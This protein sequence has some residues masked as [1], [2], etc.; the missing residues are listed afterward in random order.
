MTLTA[1]VFPKLRTLK[2]W[3]DKCL[4]SPFS[5]DPST[6]DM[7]IG[8]K[9]CWNLNDS[10]FTI[11]I[12][13]CEENHALKIFCDWY[14]K[15]SDCL[16]T[17]WLPMTSILFLTEAI[18]CNIFRWIYL[19]KEKHFLNLFLHFLNLEAFLNISKGNMTLIADVFLKLRT[20]KYDVREMSK[21]FRFR[22]P[23]DKWHGKRAKT[24]LKSERQHLYHIYWSLW[25]QFSWRMSLLVIC[26]S[27]GLFLNALMAD[28][29][30]CLFDRDNLLQFFR[31]NYLG[32]KKIFC[33]FF[34]A[35]WKSWFKLQHF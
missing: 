35:L 6:S 18:Y 11:F 10:T 24:L 13:R 29:K 12:D 3:L 19:R 7:V 4:K 22:R 15:S 9:H 25:T 20:P 30:Y 33:Q 28:D 26:K 8:P 16:L 5:E 17:H 34:C 23:F 27:L 31:C 21:K 14:W 1:F 2:T 32:K